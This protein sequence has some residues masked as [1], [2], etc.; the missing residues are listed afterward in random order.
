MFM[1]DCLVDAGP[2]F[3]PVFKPALITETGNY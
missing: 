3:D 2:R 1:V